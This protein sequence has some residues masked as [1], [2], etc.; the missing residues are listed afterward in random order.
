[1]KTYAEVLNGI[2]TVLSEC[3]D[4]HVLESAPPIEFVV[5][6][7]ATGQPSVGYSW[8]GS[9]FT[10]PPALPPTQDEFVQAAQDLLDRTAR[11]RNYDSLL[12]LASYATSSNPKFKAEAEAGIAWRDTVWTMA[13]AIM[14]DVLSG[15]TPVPTVENFLTALPRITW[16]EEA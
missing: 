11:E 7:E 8:D 2:V 13:Y 6:S 15:R 16:P 4:D 9:Q 5:L 10:P 1:M 14:A 12:S 3:E